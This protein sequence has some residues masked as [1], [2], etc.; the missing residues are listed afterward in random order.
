M[1][2]V[3]A[4]SLAH[5]GPPAPVGVGEPAPQTPESGSAVPEPGPGP[6]E[7]IRVRER[8]EDQWLM[9]AL[10]PGFG[11]AI[12][13]T[14][15]LFGP[16]NPGDPGWWLGHLWFVG[17]AAVIYGA[18]RT[19]LFA[20]RRYADWFSRPIARLVLLATGIVFG[21]I[22]PTVLMM[23]FWEAMSQVRVEGALATV[24]LVNI[25]CVLFVTWLYEMLFL[26]RERVDDQ[27]HLAE[28]EAAQTRAELLA[29]RAQ[30]DPHFL[31]NALNTLTG[32]I[33]RR[34]GDAR[35]FVSHLARVYRSLLDSRDRPLV[36]LEE[37]LA[38]ATAY[39][40]LLDIRFGGAV[41][42]EVRAPSQAWLVPVGSAQI[43]LENVIRHNAI[44][45]EAPLPIVV[46][47]TRGALTVSH[48]RRPRPPAPGAGLGLSN[49]DARS[50][51]FTGRGITVESGDDYRVTVPLVQP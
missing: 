34:P 27:V 16:L 49:L 17:G 6:V 30:V 43:L 3:E 2:S 29:L 45:P 13:H 33:D 36:P 19:L 48:P 42:T 18:N 44:D 23:T 5:A 39:A 14:T 31:F 32:L 51:A 50:R 24:L 11:I 12:P 10:I 37:E 7:Q 46:D 22:P 35:R 40:G 9:A 1:S 28:V 26:I 4:P 15:G 25:I 41:T 20:G 8:I 47:A 21:T 38:L